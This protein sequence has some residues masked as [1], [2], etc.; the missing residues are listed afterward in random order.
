MAAP[1]TKG[2]ISNFSGT[3]IDN[4]GKPYFVFAA[5]FKSS[6]G[7]PGFPIPLELVFYVD[8]LKKSVRPLIS[9]R[10]VISAWSTGHFV[11]ITLDS[12]FPSNAMRVSKVKI[13]KEKSNKRLRS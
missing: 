3:F 6:E 10:N 1:F 7:M 13:Q 5:Q 9:S 4:D 11:D 12:T 2:R 8:L